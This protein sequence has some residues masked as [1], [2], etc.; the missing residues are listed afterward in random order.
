LF[1]AAAIAIQNAQLYRDAYQAA[2]TDDL[3]GLANTRRFHRV[4]PELLAR[5]GPVALL[6]LDLD[7]FKALV[8]TEGHLIGSRTIG[9]VGSLVARCLRPVDV[10]ARFGG[11]EFVVILP[12]ADG[13]AARGIA[14]VIRA[15]IAAAR[16]LDG[17]E[18]DISAIT[19]SVGVAVFP[20]EAADAEGLFRAADTAMYGVKRGGKNSVGAAALPG[21]ETVALCATMS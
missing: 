14:E 9:H 7:N 15:T 3:T 19:A 21:V 16:V 11:D 4:L 8:D 2:N 1:D 13:P 10:A 12:G 5:G 6:V 17:T 18:V 20:A